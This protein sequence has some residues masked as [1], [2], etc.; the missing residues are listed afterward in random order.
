MDADL[1]VSEAAFGL[2]GRLFGL[3]LP[4]ALGEPD[5]ALDGIEGLSSSAV[6]CYYLH[7]IPSFETLRGQPR[8]DRLVAACPM[9]GA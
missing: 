8:H 1:P 4:L 2:L 7:R 5:R 9:R 3:E 6:R